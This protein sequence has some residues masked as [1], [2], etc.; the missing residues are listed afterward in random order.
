MS[1]WRTHS[2]HRPCLPPCPLRSLRRSLRCLHHPALTHPQ[3]T[4]TPTNRRCRSSG[5][6]PFPS[7]SSSSS[8]SP[9]P[10]ST[11]FSLSS[12]SSSPSPT[13]C[14]TSRTSLTP[15][16]ALTS[17]S[18]ACDTL[19]WT[20]T[21]LQQLT[22]L[23]RVPCAVL[24]GPGICK[25]LANLCRFSPPPPR[26]VLLLLLHVPPPPPS[27]PCAPS[28][29]PQWT[30]TECRGGPQLVLLLGQNSTV[31][32]LR[33]TNSAGVTS[34]TPSLALCPHLT[35]VR[36]S[37]LST[38]S[39]RASSTRPRSSPRVQ[40][41]PSLRTLRLDCPDGRLTAEHLLLR[42]S[43]NTPREQ[44]TPSRSIARRRLSVGVA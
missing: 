12:P 15:S 16:P 43:P 39:S 30:G 44:D 19:A 5:H 1:R 40:R 11:L 21:L 7:P 14:C 8:S 33:T 36:L 28:P 38:P 37:S 17:L 23:S 27:A 25:P 3:H 10:P 18:F 35:A 29:S 4:N 31:R 32:S 41:R 24:L 2:S 26:L 34:P 20:P 13:S 6:P 42:R 9:L 22:L